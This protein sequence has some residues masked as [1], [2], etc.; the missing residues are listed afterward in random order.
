[1]TPAGFQLNPTFSFTLLGTFAIY[2][3]TRPPRRA[4][5]WLGVIAA[6]MRWGCAALMGGLG[7]YFGVAWISWGAFLGLASLV[8]LL[9][10][11]IFPRGDER[12]SHTR[13]FYAGSVFPLLGMAVGIYFPLNVRLSPK[14]L[15]SFLLAFDGSLGF[16]PSFVLGRIVARSH[17]L[18]NWTT[19]VYYAVPFAASVLYAAHRVRK[20]QPIPVL[21]LLLSF[22]I[23]GVAQYGIFP[24]VGPAHAFSE[25]YPW[26]SPRLG[27][28]LL[29]PMIVGSEPRN[30]IPSL[31][32]GTALLVWWNSRIW[33]TWAR[34]VALLFLFATAFS[35]LAMGEHYLVDLVVAFPFA[36]VFQALWTKTVPLNLNVRFLPAVVGIGLY[37]AWLFA[38]RYGIP[39]FEKSSSW[40]W[41]ALVLTVG[42]SI[43][44]EGRLAATAKNHSCQAS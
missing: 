4:L 7:N 22:M 1:M 12:R 11:A 29:Q 44:L 35:T 6:L 27:G 21:P 37:L 3:W 14:T 30:C 31:H 26:N 24:A 40:S 8:V 13:T 19:L 16:Q 42:F 36:L 25:F 41:A 9:V 33:P 43:L 38:L 17:A 15:D 2:L 5:L 28:I 34:A 20:Q 32:F 39:F 10:Q 23:A 18:W